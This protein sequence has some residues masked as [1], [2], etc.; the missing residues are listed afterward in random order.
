MARLFPLTAC[1]GSGA[2]R[3]AQPPLRRDV[4]ATDLHAQDLADHP[5]RGDADVEPRSRPQAVVAE[6]A[7]NVGAAVADRHVARA[8]ARTAA[9]VAAQL[10]RA[11]RGHVAYQ[12]LAVAGP[13]AGEEPRVRD[14]GG[15]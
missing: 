11:A 4:G 6:Q 12:Q 9:A 3:Q 5:R 8:L 1:G 14:P 2:R 13:S 15:D 7:M 10:Y